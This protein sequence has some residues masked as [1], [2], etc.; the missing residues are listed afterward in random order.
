MQESTKTISEPIK[1]YLNNDLIE[2]TDLNSRDTLLEYL[3]TTKKLTGTKEGCGEGDCG[4]CTVLIGRLS[5]GNL[6]YETVNACICLM[7]SID[8]CHV[9]TIEFLSMFNVPLHPVQQAIVKNNGSQCGFCTPGIVMSLYGLWLNSSDFTDGNIEKNLQGNL[10]RCTGY[11]SIILAAK[12]LKQYGKLSDDTLYRNNINYKN[13]LMDLCSE[14]IKFGGDKESFFYLPKT[15]SELDTI[16]AQ[17]SNATLVAGSTDVGLWITKELS[18]INPLIF[19]NHLQELKLVRELKDGLEIGACVSYSEAKPVLSKYFPALEAYF[20][21]IAGEQVRNMGTLGGNIANGS[22]IGDMAPI[23]IALRAKILLSKSGIKRSILIEEFF[24]DYGKQDLDR[25]E[26]IEKIFVPLDEKLDLYAY[27][28]SKR[29]DEDIT[30]VSAAISIKKENNIVNEPIVAFGGMAGI[31]K[32]SFA[33]ENVING[34]KLDELTVKLAGLALEEEF[35]P[36]TDARASADYRILVAKNL[37]QKFFL[38]YEGQD[39]VMIKRDN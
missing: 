33:A 6:K 9:I 19:I 28:L 39:P 36:L 5:A 38:E 4:A 26:F 32:R 3:R 15:L 27:K 18:T 14:S 7:P 30:I 21:R 20:L 22:P 31:P 16:Y 29:R 1:F 24:L 34:R 10:C 17:N 2:T 13:N 35:T 8:G 37:L 11:N 25:G 12:S 23:L